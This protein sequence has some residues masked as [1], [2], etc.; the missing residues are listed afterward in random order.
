MNFIDSILDFTSKKLKE[1]STVL[2]LDTIDAGTKTIPAN[3]YVAID[4]SYIPP[5]GY[6]I[7]MHTCTVSSYKAIAN[8]YYSP[9]NKKFTGAVWSLGGSGGSAS[10]K[11]SVILQKAQ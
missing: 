9:S 11:I 8:I 7:M 2:K 5:E 10:V 1:L 3:G 4:E 6:E